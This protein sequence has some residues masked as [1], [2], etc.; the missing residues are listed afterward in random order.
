MQRAGRR[1]DDLTQ[2]GDEGSG[3]LRPVGA[4]LG[5]PRIDHAREALTELRLDCIEHRRQR[6][7]VHVPEAVNAFRVEGSLTGKQFERGHRKAVHVGSPVDCVDPVTLGTPPLLRRHVA[8]RADR[9]TGLGQAPG[10]VRMLLDEAG[11]TEIDDLG[12]ERSIG[13]RE[14]H[15]LGLEVAVHDAGPV[16][17]VERSGNLLEDGEGVQRIE[18]SPSAELRPERNAVDVL[19]DEV[20]GTFVRDAQVVNDDCVRV[21]KPARGLAFAQESPEPLRISRGAVGQHLDGDGVAEQHVART[22][23]GSHA[24][25]ADERFD[26]VETVERR[27]DEQ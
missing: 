2:F 26:V 25:A 19:E 4:V 6:A 20:D 13:G 15:V 17:R 18:A 7:D 10:D 27:A 5:E 11:E 22:K 23:D 21:A 8:R 14:H 12:D 1:R 16:R 9:R 24:A 3:G